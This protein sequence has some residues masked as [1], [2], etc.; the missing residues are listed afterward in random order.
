MYEAFFGLDGRP[1][2]PVPRVDHFFPAATIEAARQTL[3]RCIQRAEGV[4]MVVGPSGTGKTLL[5]HVLADHFQ[6]GLKTVLLS[7]G[8]LGTRRALLQAILHGLGQPYRG[9]DEGELRLA[10]VDCLVSAENC[11]AG[12][13]ILVDE[14]HTLPLR[15]LDEI[16]LLTNLVCHGQAQVR[17]VLAGGPILE[18]RFASPRLDSFSQRLVARCYLESFRRDETEAYIGTQVRRMGGDGGLFPPEVCHAVHR[19]TDGIPRLVNQ[20]CDHALVLAY[21]AGKSPIEA[22][23]IEEAWADLQQLPTPWNG[24]AREQKSTGGVIEFGGLVDEPEPA[25]AAGRPDDDG[26]QTS[27][28]ACQGPSDADAPVPPDE[29]LTR[30]EQQLSELNEDFQPAGSIRPEVEL[31]ID[32]PANPLNEPFQEEEIVRDRYPAAIDGHR[33][34]AAG[35]EQAA[36]AGRGP[37][38]L[39]CLPV[40]QAPGTEADEINVEDDDDP[41]DESEWTCRVA[42]VRRHEY[43]QLFARLRR[44]C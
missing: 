7:S 22:A 40:D 42:T 9:M 5:C 26:S 8:R 21:A 38:P 19:A 43:R 39:R 2:A 35:A 24:E 12:A 23:T 29:Q 14:A 41:P 1:F 10:L 36:G 16:R 3:S 27:W 25:A 20:V 31:V 15:L 33:R 44:S 11:P 32:D 4:G 13:L 34:K 37:V 6:E 30:I 17:L 18:E 28:P